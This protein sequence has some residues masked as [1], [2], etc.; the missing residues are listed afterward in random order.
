VNADDVDELL[1]ERL[2]ARLAECK[3][4]KAE[5]RRLRAELDRRRAY[6]LEA[7]RQTRLGRTDPKDAA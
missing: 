3:R 2:T 1:A 6:G 7:R 5:T 4:R